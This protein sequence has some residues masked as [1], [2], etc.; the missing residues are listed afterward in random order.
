[1]CYANDEVGFKRLH[2]TEQ[3]LCHLFDILE[4]ADSGPGPLTAKGGARG[5]CE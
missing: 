2:S 1:V 5:N 3:C 4:K